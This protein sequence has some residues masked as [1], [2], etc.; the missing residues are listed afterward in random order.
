MQ[1][2]LLSELPMSDPASVGTE[3][4]TVSP[5]ELS[6][7]SPVDL[8]RCAHALALRREYR[9][10]ID[11]YHRLAQ[12]HPE[13]ST[14]GH[15]MVE[16]CAALHRRS[17]APPGPSLPAP[18]AIPTEL[19]PGPAEPTDGAS[20]QLLALLSTSAPD[21]PTPPPNSP[22][23]FAPS[24]ERPVGMAI[25]QASFDEE[26]ALVC[27]RGWL[28]DP[29][30]AIERIAIELP[31][32]APCSGQAAGR[33]ARGD[34]L[35]MLQ[36]IGLSEPTLSRTLE[37][38]GFAISLFLPAGA[39]APEALGLRVELA[40]GSCHRL[41]AEVI[42]TADAVAAA[43]QHIDLAI[44]AA[45]ELSSTQAL[46]VL[47]Q[48]WAER[49]SALLAELAL[50][51]SFGTPEREPELSVVVPLYGR[52][53][54]MEYQLNWFHA[55]RRRRGP[56][57]PEIQLIYVLDD[58]RLHQ[59]FMALAGRCRMLYDVPFEIVVNPRNLGFS[60]ANNRGAACA[61]APWLLLL[62]SDVLPADDHA[63][64]NL[65]EA[66]KAGGE[67]LGALGAR[68]SFENGDVQHVGMEFRQ[69]PELHGVLGRV[70]LNDHP[71]KGLALQ[72]SP[73]HE[74][75]VEV[76][77]ATAAC[78]L[79]GTERY[80]SLGGLSSGYIVGDFEDSDLCLRLRELGLTIQVHRGARFFHLER[81]SV[82]SDEARDQIRAK[83]VATN[84]VLHHLRW[85]NTI[86]SLKQAAA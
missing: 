5:T 49:A 33:Q 3:L 58:P 62:N 84:A 1:R 15:T 70:W 18:A 71:L 72:A 79:L 44:S 57:Q 43:K 64:S 46:Q 16:T 27:I 20:L 38:A 68:L 40:D 55:W 75:P 74:A 2:P 51:R 73:G 54:F 4:S 48:R 41:G 12:D 7:S 11:L 30:Q 67:Q 86:A 69:R 26:L 24:L 31:G 47:S 56:E 80:R 34:L 36:T 39:T 32:G 42:C 53:D 22:A 6:G 37:E 66:M 65:L 61:R 28:V 21:L 29:L 19:Q 50:H 10:A 82:G 35:G 25:D 59:A 63:F 83:L 81:Q 60:G 78:L 85:S 76:E 23:A 45:M 8:L 9:Q 52:I 17:A 13:L 77:A 14:L